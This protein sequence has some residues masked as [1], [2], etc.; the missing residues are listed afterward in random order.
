MTGILNTQNWQIKTIGDCCIIGDGAHAKIK[1]Q[2][3]GILYLTCKNFKNGKLELSKVDYISVAD[4]EKHFR[5]DS[6]ALT[7]PKVNDVIFSIIGTIGEPYLYKVTD[8]FGI[9]SSVSLLR[10]GTQLLLPKYLYYWIKGHIFQDALYGI[11]GGVAQ[12]YVSLEMIKKL[13]LY[14]PPLP[15]QQ[16]IAAIL[17]TYDDLIEN[18]ARRIEILEEM[19]RMLYREW[20]VKF[21]Y[22]G[23][24]SDRLVESELGLIPKG[25][26][27]VKIGDVIELA[28]G[29]SLT[30]K[31]RI[32]GEFPV[33]GSAGIVGY[34][35]KSLVKSPGVVVGRKGNVGRV[36]WANKDF[37]PIDTVFYIVTNVCLN[38][39]FYNLQYQNFINNDAAVPGLSRNQAYLLPFLV[40]IEKVVNKFKNYSDTVFKQI[41]ILQ[42][43]N[44]NLRQT[45]DLLLPRLI[46][47]EI[48]VENLKIK[49][50]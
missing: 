25:W 33:Y 46:S 36:F 45:R 47:G 38:Y 5:E 10:P 32:P 4:Y 30:A 7:K 44:N 21:R 6:K 29:K 28:Y 37:F 13:P 20:F 11:K 49:T 42:E 48:D 18:N 16:K 3:T 1:R 23:H 40:P 2:K 50:E 12:G 26:E 24:E 9:S 35:N 17:S 34:H 41:Q 15:I 8:R 19:A 39:V 43:K 27:V 31:N 14:Y 22:P